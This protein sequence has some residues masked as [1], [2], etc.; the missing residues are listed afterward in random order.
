[1]SDILYTK[2]PVFLFQENGPKTLMTHLALGCMHIS[3]Q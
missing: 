1:M 2:F 3:V